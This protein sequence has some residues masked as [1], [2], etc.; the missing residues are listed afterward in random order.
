MRKHIIL[1]LAA[2]PSGTDPRALDR[3]ARS[4]QVELERSGFRECFEL[5]TRWAV[6]PLDLIREL[7]ELQP[8]VVHFSGH[9]GEN[10][11]FFQ[12]EEGRA[13][14][15]A[16]AALA[17]AFG[18][19]G[20]SV[21]LVVLNACY[22]EVQA[23]ALLA[24]VDHVVG[25][26]GSL[27]EDAA[28]IF[29]IGFYGGL[30]G[31]ESIADAFRQGRAA[32]DLQGLSDGD[33]PQLRGRAGVDADGLILAATTAPDAVDAI[34]R[35]SGSAPG[36]EPTMQSF[37]AEEL[38]RAEREAAEI[39][40]VW[41]PGPALRIQV[42][43]AASIGVGLFVL[44]LLVLPC[45]LLSPPAPVGTPQIVL[46]AS[47]LTAGVLWALNP[48][49][50][51][52][53]FA[54]SLLTVIVLPAS[55]VWSWVS[56]LRGVPASSAGLPLVTQLAMIG[57]VCL[58]L[59]L[60]YRAHREQDSLVSRLRLALEKLAF[61]RQLKGLSD[62]RRYQSEIV[63]LKDRCRS[64]QNRERY[65]VYVGVAILLCSTAWRIID[66]V[67]RPTL[68]AGNEWISQQ[69]PDA[70]SG[71]PLVVDGSMADG[72][73]RDGSVRPPDAVPPKSL[74]SI[75]ASDP[76]KLSPDAQLEPR[77][78]GIARIEVPTGMERPAEELE[79]DSIERK[80]SLPVSTQS[81]RHRPSFVKV[82]TDHS[83]AEGI[84]IALR[85][86][87]RKVES[88]IYLRRSMELPPAAM[89]STWGT[90][91]FRLKVMAPS[92][93]M[94]PIGFG[95]VVVCKLD[96]QVDQWTGTSLI[97]GIHF[98]DQARIETRADTRGVQFTVAK[99]MERVVTL[100]M[101]GQVLP[102]LE[103]AIKAKL[104]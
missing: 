35:G 68:P 83:S 26:G 20:A 21:K 63:D 11:L 79:G 4:I 91:A 45:D 97:G 14:L 15:V 12:T 41:R 101:L 24:H 95:Y 18:A 74:G 23:N 85:L 43:I 103:S 90:L 42:V 75:L 64:N 27:H 55:P 62:D 44:L 58:C 84:Q 39:V 29:A 72:V 38:A 56:E 32:I 49:R 16:P 2:N 30:V 71:W 22:S 8:T 37:S 46:G 54:V 51:Y 36:A 5:V 1:F 47:A 65:A 70:A 31:R 94:M 61:S 86:I 3:E 104:P 102:S 25:I 28:R 13:Q 66:V 34:T 53:R 89:L 17:E 50:R 76:S 77:G 100:L 81:F 40:S 9:G 88:S 67:T 69:I 60:D 80:R 6:E 52:L 93:K 87:E 57:V 99:C 7:R 98:N 96:V 19:A 92:I 48:R 33:R 82:A 10:G 78:G 73:E 59:I